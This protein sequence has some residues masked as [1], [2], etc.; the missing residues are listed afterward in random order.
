M[1]MMNTISLTD[2][3]ALPGRPT[4]DARAMTGEN[5][6]A[7]IVLDEKVYTL[8]ITKAGKLILTK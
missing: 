3:A 4:F 1:T 8:R 7:Q 2:S 6:L 5:G